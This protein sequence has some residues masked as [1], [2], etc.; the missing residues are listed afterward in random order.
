M[1]DALWIE[2]TQHGKTVAAAVCGHVVRN[3]TQPLGFVEN[4]DDPDDLQGW[5]FACEYVYLQEEDKTPRFI[6][7]CQHSIV[8]SMCYRDI[9][10]FHQ[11]AEGDN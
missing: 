7:F 1:A 10:M 9:K 11:V 6:G 8:C 5:C 2:C 4:S 3:R